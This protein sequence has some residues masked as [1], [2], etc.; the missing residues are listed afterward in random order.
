MLASANAGHRRVSASLPGLFSQPRLGQ[1]RD[2]CH[3]MD[4]RNVCAAG[5]KDLRAVADLPGS[6]VDGGLGIAWL[7]FCALRDVETSP[8]SDC[9]F[10]PARP[11][12]VISE[13]SNRSEATKPGRVDGNRASQVF[14]SGSRS[15]GASCHV[16]GVNSAG[17]PCPADTPDRRLPTR[18]RARRGGPPDRSMVVT[19]VRPNGRCRKPRRCIGEH[20]NRVG[21]S[22]SSRWIHVVPTDVRQFVERSHSSTISNSI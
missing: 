10:R 21:G 20:C 4:C 15:C 14:A 1:S 6:H 5:S 22:C 11:E 13:A 3:C 12:I 19:A 2:R 8:R 17:L 16:P 7:C 18:H 9:Q